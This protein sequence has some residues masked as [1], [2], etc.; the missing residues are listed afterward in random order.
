M[1]QYCADEPRRRGVGDYKPL[2]WFG[3]QAELHLATT[4]G[5][6][7][8][9]RHGF[10]LSA[11]SRTSS[12]WATELPRDRDEKTCQIPKLRVAPTTIMSPDI[13]VGSGKLLRISE[14]RNGSRGIE[15]RSTGSCFSTLYVL[16]TQGR[17]IT[18]KWPSS[19]VSLRQKKPWK[20]QVMRLMLA[21]IFWLSKI[22]PQFKKIRRC[23]SIYFLNLLF[24]LLLETK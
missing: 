15:G 4:G 18:R 16:V 1:I 21:S 19:K 22:N 3:F 24:F 5:G 14:R 23:D 7:R 10:I 17:L 8:A 9:G 11:F 6:K 20:C 13:T 12:K 2:Q